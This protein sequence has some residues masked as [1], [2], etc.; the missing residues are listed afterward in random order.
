MGVVVISFTSSGSFDHMESFL[1]SMKKMNVRP[2][3]ESCGAQGVA[4]LIAA[5]PRDSGLAA[6][7][8]HYTVDITAGGATVTWH[9]TDVENG[10]PVAIA[11][12]YG[13]ATGTGGYVQGRDYINPAIKPIFDQIESEIWKAV[14]S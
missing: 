13:Y 11:L 1:G 12:Q 8:W 3:L 7:S 6:S 2:I 14:A 5:T 10:F 9:N 4:A